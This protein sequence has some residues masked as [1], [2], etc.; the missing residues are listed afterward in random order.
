M[1][2]IG[3]GSGYGTKLI[4]KYFKPK[5]IYGIDLDEEMIN[6]ANKNKL[7]NALF[8]VGGATKLDFKDN[9]LDGIFI[10]LVL[11]HIPNWKEALD[12]FYR[13]LKK[14][15]VCFVG[16]RNNIF[17]A[18]FALRRTSIKPIA[19]LVFPVPVA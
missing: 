7:P 17:C 8:K 3:C 15:G 5:K 10:F 14:G 18:L 19:T 2:E 12:E 11:H 6:L 13:V 4:N 1:L 9:S 16:A